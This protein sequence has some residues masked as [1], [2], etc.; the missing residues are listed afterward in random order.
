VCAA[1]FHGAGWGMVVLL[2]FDCIL[3]AVDVMTHLTRFLQQVL[4]H[5]HVRKMSEIE[6]RQIRL[7]VDMRRRNNGGGGGGTDAAGVASEGL[8][9]DDYST[10]HEEQQQQQQ[11][12]NHNDIR[13]ASIR[14]DQ[15]M[16]ALEAKH[17][18]RL[19]ILDYTAFV[20]DLLA[21]ILTIGH[22]LHIWSINGIQFNLVDGV[23]ALHLHTAVATIG[24]KIAERR[25]RNRI[26]RDLDT[27]CEDATD[28][29]MH[30]ASASGDVCCI[31]LGTMSMGN[32][33]KIG[34]G[35]LY[36]TNC[37]RE[38]V[39]RA[40]SIEAAKCPLCRTLIVSGK[41]AP[42]N[43]GAS[44]ELLIFGGNNNIQTVGGRDIQNRPQQDGINENINNDGW[45]GN[46]GVEGVGDRQDNEP[47]LGA[48]I[49][50]VNE[51]PLFRFSTEGFLPTW[52]PIPA[53]SFEIVRRPVA[54]TNGGADDNGGLRPNT[55]QNQQL[56]RQEQQPQEPQQNMEQLLQQ[57]QQPQPQPQPQLQPQPQ[58]QPQQS[59]FRR[60]LS[61]AL[62]GAVPMSPEDEA[63]ATMQLVDMFPQYD[64]ADLLRELRD[65]GSITLVAEA[66]LNGT[67]SGIA[68]PGAL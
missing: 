60:F 42:T 11:P 28:L 17:Q 12:M 1:L 46:G 40:R 20:L 31:C 27:F 3:L 49:L 4:E 51:R 7:H 25:N 24:K 52:L 21:C 5:V 6:A 8:F 68:R 30:K 13:E 10:H 32:V 63:L 33:K 50:N 61:L 29:D 36:H 45:G 34:C 38:I 37:L 54:V 41:Q 56:Q 48:E 15:Q 18:R 26:T 35:H 9:A 43:N 47:F 59:L 14:Y 67:F 57:P 53:F 23:L 66:I 55:A 39:E 2:T 58:P 19:S 64:R 62:A 22:F 65:R 44:P 16:E